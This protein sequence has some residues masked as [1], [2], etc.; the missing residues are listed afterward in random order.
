[1]L[2]CSSGGAAA[3]RRAVITGASSGIGEAF[4]RVLPPCADLL[5]T[6][7]DRD[8]LDRLAAE[9]ATPGR[10]VQTLASDL[11]EDRGVRDLIERAEAFEVDLLV[12]NA[13]VG[14]WGRI[15]DHSPEDERAT[16][17]LNAVAV[18]S[19]TRGL[20]PG[21]LARARATGRRSGL[22]IVAS[23]AAFAPVPFF[24]TYAATKAF[25]LAYAE[26][27]AEEMLGEPVDV[28]ALCP[29]ATRTA[30]G[31]RA[32]FRGGG[33]PGALDAET[34]ARQGLAALGRQTVKVTGLVDQTILTP[35][36]LRR[37]LLAGA[38]G[39]AL[40]VVHGF[41]RLR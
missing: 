3:F 29:G 5:L 14:H 19:L 26:A 13:G 25:D 27:L 32:G 7:R 31:E 40:R 39:A 23:S 15:L 10:S 37:R 17:M 16:V 33:L 1:M 30:F 21:M 8:R 34:V 41:E 4:A 9:L 18:A 6:G 35:A 2:K 38:L 12:N 22:V 24:A 36:V 20:L 11:A 28:L